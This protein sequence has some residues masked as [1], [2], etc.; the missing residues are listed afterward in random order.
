MFIYELARD[1]AQLERMTCHSPNGDDTVRFTEPDM[2]SPENWLGKTGCFGPLRY[3]YDVPQIDESRAILHVRDPRDVLVSQFYSKA[4]SH[5]EVAYPDGSRCR[6]Y[7]PQW[8]EDGIDDFIFS[9][10]P[11][12]DYTWCDRLHTVYTRY[13]RN[14]LDRE[15]VTL[16]TYEEMVSNYQAWLKTVISGLS[17]ADPDGAYEILYERYKDSF[18]V[19]GEDVNR[20]KRQVAPGDHR[21]KLKPETIE[22]LN[23]NFAEVMGKFGYL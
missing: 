4:F 13:C 21:R 23:E 10:I 6:D 18:T 1:I 22:K 11:A 16:V 8:I 2:H 3:C 15:N 7:R 14:L 17:L 12:Q 19:D 5:R 9:L 20:H